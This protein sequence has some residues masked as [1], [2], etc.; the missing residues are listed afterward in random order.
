MDGCEVCV[1]R[2]EGILLVMGRACAWWVCVSEIANA[3]LHIDRDSRF[4]FRISRPRQFR[5]DE[6]AKKRSAARV[7]AVASA[8]FAN[9]VCC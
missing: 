1:Q 4:I 2:V 8:W 6:V 9:L 3:E 5:I 7:P